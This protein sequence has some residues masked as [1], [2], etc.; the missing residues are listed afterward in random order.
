MN[1]YRTSTGTVEAVTTFFM[2]LLYRGGLVFVAILIWAFALD[3]DKKS[4]LTVAGV[5]GAVI[6]AYDGVGLAFVGRRDVFGRLVLG[7]AMVSGLI[8]GAVWLL[9]SIF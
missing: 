8:G 5:M 3:V 7:V 9:R 1:K 6:G 2:V 4:W